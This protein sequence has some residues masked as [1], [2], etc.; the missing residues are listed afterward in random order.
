MSTEPPLIAD[1]FE[2][3]KR[4]TLKP[5]VDFNTY[6][7]N[8]FGDGPCRCHRCLEL[9]G[10]ESGYT[11]RHTFVM[12]GQPVHRRFAMTAGSDVLQALKKA[13]LSYTKTDLNARGELEIETV[14]G[15]TDASLHERLLALLPASGLAREDAGTWHLQAVGD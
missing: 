1:L 10:D 13:W 8:A 6:L 5:V 12:Q 14:K 3:D 9:Q 2:T 15:F 11:Y 7:R 4:L